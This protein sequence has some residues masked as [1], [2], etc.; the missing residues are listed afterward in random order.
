MGEDRPGFPLLVT[1]IGGLFCPAHLYL[2]ELAVFRALATGSLHG[3]AYVLCGWLR[4]LEAQGLCWDDPSP[5]FL[6]WA[7]SSDD[8]KR[9]TVARRQWRAHVVFDFY[10]HAFRNGH[11][12]VSIGA[13][14]DAF[15]APVP[16]E[17]LVSGV[18]VRRRLRVKFGRSPARVGG[19]RPTPSE[20]AVDRIAEALLG[21]GEDY[22]QIRNWMLVRTAYETNLRTQGLAQLTVSLL[23]EM[24]F[25]RGVIGSSA[26][27]ADLPPQGRAEARARLSMLEERG[28]TAFISAPLYEKGK[29]RRVRFPVVLMRQL[30]D[31]VWAE[32]ALFLDQ[33]CGGAVKARAGGALWLS[34]K[35][36]EALRRGTIADLLK[37]GFSEAGE[38][39]SGHR[40]RAASAIRLLRNTVRR[41]RTNQAGRFDA[42]L[43]LTR[44]AEEMGHESP[45]TLRPYLNAV[46]LEDLLADT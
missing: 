9:L 14:L 20:A 32:R 25:R 21:D 4:H 11:E 12:T 45:A 38:P 28:L 39:G 36:G 40:I 37:R 19:L 8:A 3:V 30:M 7:K 44:V 23:D 17:A 18:R 46:L 10:E 29:H 27:L 33:R 6:A 42:E 35:T 5:A 1:P 2:C 22:Q 34:N 16:A 26:G 13:F 41:A 15:S 24:L 43:I 31:Y